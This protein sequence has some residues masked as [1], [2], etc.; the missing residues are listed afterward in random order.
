MIFVFRNEIKILL[1]L[2][3]LREKYSKNEEIFIGDKGSRRKKK[4]GKK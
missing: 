4:K 1:L 3:F 2:L